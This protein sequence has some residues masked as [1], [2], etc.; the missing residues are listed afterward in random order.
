MQVFHGH[1]SV[2]HR[3]KRPALT[4]GNFD[5]LHLGHQELIRR[6]IAS[7]QIL[8]TEALALTFTPHP[9]RVLPSKDPPRLLMT[10][11]QKEQGFRAAGLGA[12]VFEP[13]DQTFAALKAEAFVQDVLL[14]ALD[15]GEVIVG[16]CFRFG[17]QGRG[18][19][20]LL[21]TLLQAAGRRLQVV[22]HLHVEGVRCSSSRIRELL[23]LGQVENAIRLLGHPP[24]LSGTVVK[25]DGRGRLIHTP[26]YNLAVE[27]ELIPAKGV[28]VTRS[29]FHGEP[30]SRLSVTN[31]GTRPTFDG[32][33]SLH[34]ETH[35]LDYEGDLYGKS[36]TVQ[37]LARLRDEMRFES[38]EELKAQI[39]RDIAEA[40]RR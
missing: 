27:Q 39:A 6:A 13:F 3:F 25:G 9:S 12:A 11:R 32:E 16:E 37:F 14:G 2:R 26:T 17:S 8:G 30:A 36:V 5:G 40:R 21:D 34:V 15:V 24:T 29:I 35:V 4:I 33:P 20:Q 28:Y 10:D 19:T 7:A 22:P 23:T 18:D 31:I 38:I 1:E